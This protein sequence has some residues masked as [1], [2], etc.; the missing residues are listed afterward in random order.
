MDAQIPA[1]RHILCKWR[2]APN[3]FFTC[4]PDGAIFQSTI[5]HSDFH[6]TVPGWCSPESP[7]TPTTIQTQSDTYQPTTDSDNLTTPAM[8]T[9]MSV[10]TT[11]NYS[12]TTFLTTSEIQT[13]S[14]WDYDF[15]N[16]TRSI[17]T[18]TVSWHT[19]NLT[20]S[21]TY[22]TIT[23]P[24]STSTTISTDISERT[25]AETRGQQSSTSL[26]LGL[27]SS[28]VFFCLLSDFLI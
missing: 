4:P 27:K 3:P 8:V 16:S 11:T 9:T 10:L 7:S 19:S 22:T 25:T 26:L 20:S 6:P 2:S 24:P 23:E 5:C 17:S 15:T 12:S 28:I 21:E 18:D 14:S 1:T 13:T